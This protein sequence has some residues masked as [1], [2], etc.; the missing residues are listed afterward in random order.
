M[1][2]RAVGALY[3]I[4]GYA[5]DGVCLT[6]LD[7]TRSIRAVATLPRTF[8]LL[9]A[10]T[11]VNRLG[12][13]VVPFLTLYLTEH[14]G[15]S[16]AQAG[17]A[18]SLW[19]S[20]MVIA[21][22]LGGWLS[23]RVGRKATM[24][25]GLTSAAGGVAAMGFATSFLTVGAS[26]LF[27]GAAGE[28]YRP[29]VS[30][31][32]AD[33]VPPEDRPRAYGHLYW[34]VNLG[35]ALAPIGA[36]LLMPFG[37]RWILIVDASTT[38]VYAFIVLLF[39]PETRPGSPRETVASR[40]SGVSPLRDP[41][42]VVFVG[43]TVMTAFVLSQTHTAL[44]LTMKARGLSAVGYGRILSAN[45]LLIVVLQPFA[46]R[47]FQRL[48][49]S[50]VLAAGA[51][52]MGV[53]FGLHAL[54]TTGWEFVAAVAVWTLGEI[55]LTAVGPSVVADLAPE[56]LRGTY[57][58]IYGMAWALATATAP[59]AGAMLLNSFGFRVVWGS[60]LAIGM[61]AAAG[62][63]LAAG[64]RSKRLVATPGARAGTWD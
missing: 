41:S 64:A 22:P 11:L 38:L 34:A 7:E 28:M 50:V 51:L 14:D 37:Y 31:A 56:R 30:A 62:H 27:L 44:P 33:V 29:A 32:I 10:G 12:S 57:Q 59:M 55:A 19:G 53:G 43:L 1:W 25:L 54:T 45:A 21:S 18:V 17:A 52:L 35:L 23:D 2:K 4:R 60:C 20:G 63:L 47:G 49:R 24:M 48:R 39:V 5:R 13:F 61:A 15:Y 3:H 26:A 46:V 40:S 8:W 58:G 6:S 42:F 9:W 36:G 16:P